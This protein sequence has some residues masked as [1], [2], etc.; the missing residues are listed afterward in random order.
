M[1]ET[2]AAE[3]IGRRRKT[4][5]PPVGAQYNSAGGK[6]CEEVSNTKESAAESAK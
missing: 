5:D 1:T 6:Y 3:A 4:E 2:T